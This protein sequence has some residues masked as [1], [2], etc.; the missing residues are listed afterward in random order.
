MSLSR[1]ALVLLA[2]L[3]ITFSA[4]AQ[5]P[6][7]ASTPQR[8]PQAITVLTQSIAAMGGSVPSDSVATGTVTLVAGSRTETGTIRILTRG[9]D[10]TSEQIQSQYTN[11]SVNY[12]RGEA[13]EIE[14]TSTRVLQ[15]ELVVTSQCPDFALPV[16]AGALNNTQTALQYMALE[17]ISGVPAHHIRFWQTFPASQPRLAHLAEFSTKDVW[18]DAVTSLPRR[19]SS[20]RREARGAAPRIPLEI[21]YSDYRNLS[22]ALYPFRISKSLN[23]TPWV[24]ITITGVTFNTGLRDADFPVQ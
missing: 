8:D 9:S 2:F 24:T 7:P 15:K 17:T 6:P 16:F 21:N 3:T 12:S 13:S 10:Q 18:I 20:E 14:G 1:P 4:T 11:R 23:G 5:Q 19:L 22:G